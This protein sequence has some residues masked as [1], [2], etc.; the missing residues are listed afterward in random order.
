MTTYPPNPLGL[1]ASTAEAVRNITEDLFRVLHDPMIDDSP[2]TLPAVRALW[3]ITKMLNAITGSYDSFGDIP[4][5]DLS[6]A[7]WEE[8]LANAGDVAAI[9]LN[10][11]AAGKTPEEAAS[12]IAERNYSDSEAWYTATACSGTLEMIPPDH[13]ETGRI[14]TVAFD[15]MAHYTPTQQVSP[16]AVTADR[17]PAPEPRPHTASTVLRAAWLAHQLAAVLGEI[18]VEPAADGIP[19]CGREDREVTCEV[20]GRDVS[21]AIARVVQVTQPW[22]HQVRVC[23]VACARAASA[24]EHREEPR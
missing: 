24:G 19:L 7:Q 9:A 12:W 14:L 3:W 10:G 2:G 17:G 16:L 23:S 1:P 11:L 8:V 13:G 20:C 21:A 4:E 18:V 15:M 6:R 5:A 22:D